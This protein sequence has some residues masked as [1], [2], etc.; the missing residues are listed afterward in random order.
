MAGGSVGDAG[1][2]AGAGGLRDVGGVV[3]GASG[4][5]VIRLMAAVLG[6]WA[7][8]VVLFVAPSVLPEQ[9]RYYIYSPASAGLWMLTMLVAPFVVCAFTWRWI[10]TGSR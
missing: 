3:L 5:P 6:T 4:M 8:L 9:W 7:A 1:C 10:M 2:G